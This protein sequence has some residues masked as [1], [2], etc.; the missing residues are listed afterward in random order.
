MRVGELTRVLRFELIDLLSDLFLFNAEAEHVAGYFSQLIIDGSNLPAHN[1]DSLTKLSDLS[2]ERVNLLVDGDCLGERALPDW[3]RID[4]APF[5]LGLR[6]FDA[7]VQISQARVE[8]VEP[9]EDAFLEGARVRQVLSVLHAHVR[10]YEPRG[11]YV[12]ESRGG[13]CLSGSGPVAL[14]LL[15]R[16]SR[17]KAHDEVGENF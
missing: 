14:Y 15:P 6:F 7:G 10:D 9:C 17:E 3:L 16:L 13:A 11:F 2:R 4:G 1:R 8:C 12:Q 5:R